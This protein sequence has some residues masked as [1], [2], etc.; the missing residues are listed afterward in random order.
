MST[1]RPSFV[2]FLSIARR[3]CVHRSSF[4]RPSF[5]VFASIVRRF[6]VQ[7]S[8]FLRP[9]LVVVASFLRPSFVQCASIA[10][11]ASTDHICRILCVWTNR[12]NARAPPP[13]RGVAFSLFRF[14]ARSRSHT[15]AR[16]HARDRARLNAFFDRV[17]LVD[18]SI[19]RSRTP[20][21]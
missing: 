21:A 2:G 8:S 17:Q 7:F 15:R 19:E 11:R 6:C 3:F 10:R 13:P 4:L 9:V 18:R 12:T 14:F 16:E 20:R 1:R 5:V